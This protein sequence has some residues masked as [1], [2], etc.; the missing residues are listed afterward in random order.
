MVPTRLLDGIPLFSG[1]AAEQLSEL[2]RVFQRVSYPLGACVVRQGQPADSAFILESG[3]AEVLTALP[4]GGELSVARLGPGS[5][6]GEMALLDS[7]VRSATVMARTATDG[8][9]I[10]R[11]AFRMLLAQR[12]DAVFQIQQRIA[13]TLCQR[14]RGLNSRIGVSSTTQ[15]LP[16]VVAPDERAPRT[17]CAF[18][19]RAFLPVLALFRHFRPHEI[20]AFVEGLQVFDAARGAV[21]FRE[22]EAASSCHVIVRG[23]V[24]LSAMAGG[25]RRRIGVLGPGRL[26][27]ILALLENQPH[28]MT[29]VAREQATLLEMDRAAFEHLCGQRDRMAL[30]FS[31][32]INAE[33]LHSLGRANNHLT[34]LISQ[35]RIRAPGAPAPAD[36]EALQRAL[37]AQD[38]RPAAH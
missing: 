23:A 36:V 9:F 21:L 10:D 13:L 11:D 37:S 17:P 20:D 4:G 5:M 35:A 16:G 31:D 6:L 34:R 28:S 25:A 22:G 12:N 32:A 33:L 8:Y 3:D 29:A 2:M 27:G 30:K 14:L 1:L 15:H 38:L 7:G 26:C 24:E 18:D 19:Y